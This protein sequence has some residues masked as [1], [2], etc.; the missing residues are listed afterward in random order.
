LTDGHGRTIDFKNT[1]IIMTSNVG[2]ELYGLGHRAGTSMDRV[3]EQVTEELKAHFRP[4]FLNRIDEIIVF[5]PLE[6]AHLKQIVEIQL[7]RLESRLAER[8]IGIDLTDAAKELLAEEGFD[9]VY[10]A[11]PL[12][13]TLQR[14]V[15]DVLATRVLQGDFKPGDTILVDAKDGRLTFAVEREQGSP[16]AAIAAPLG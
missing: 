4:E 9:P 8:K 5:H 2:S 14:R 1:V 15:L 12:K 6:M 16:V 3:R 7:A 13:R 11:R 10:G